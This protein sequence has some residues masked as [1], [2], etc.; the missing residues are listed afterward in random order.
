MKLANAINGRRVVGAY[1]SNPNGLSG[2]FD[3]WPR[4]PNFVPSG[5]LCLLVSVGWAS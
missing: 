5:S 1:V 4:V 2:K 3:Q